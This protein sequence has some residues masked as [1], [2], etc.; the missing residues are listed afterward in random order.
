MPRYYFHTSDVA[1]GLD[2]LGEE[3]PNDEA[4]W[5]EA[6][7]VAAQI[8]RDINGKLRPNQDWTL[9]VAD[10]SRCPLFQIHISTKKLK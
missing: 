8:F 3:L 5:R 9:D 7:I 2:D 6:T 1:P 10:E 4:A